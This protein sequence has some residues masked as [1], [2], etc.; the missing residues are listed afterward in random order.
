[1]QRVELKFTCYPCGCTRNQFMY[2]T[3]PKELSTKRDIIT[4]ERKVETQCECGKKIVE[5]KLEGPESFLHELKST[6]AYSPSSI[7]RDKVSQ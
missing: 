1:M 4:L 6:V 2:R 7:T 3:S 5:E